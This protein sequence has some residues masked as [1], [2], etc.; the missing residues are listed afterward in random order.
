VEAIDR[1]G[2]SVVIK[3]RPDTK[4]QRLNLDR[5]LRVIGGRGDA[6]LVPPATIKIDLR[7]PVSGSRASDAAAPP[8]AEHS[9]GGRTGTRQATTGAV[10]H[11]AI[12]PVRVPGPTTAAV[13]GRQPEKSKPA[14]SWWT[15]RATAGEVK[16][17]FSKE[18]ILKPPKEDPSAADGVFAR[19][20]GLLTELRVQ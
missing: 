12:G 20:K 14:P 13:A 9:P 19:V 4:G 5:L 2:Q 11:T 17:G 3:F 10:R 8:A 16:A 6:T 18:E 15:A 7:A 1:E